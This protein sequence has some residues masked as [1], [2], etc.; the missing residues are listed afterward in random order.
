MSD[1]SGNGVYHIGVPFKDVPIAMVRDQEDVDVEVS[2]H[3]WKDQKY[4]QSWVVGG[5]K[6]WGF[7]VRK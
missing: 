1:E 7:V 6:D 4:L 5:I 3:A 2:L